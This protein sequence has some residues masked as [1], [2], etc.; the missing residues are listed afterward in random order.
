MDA[1]QVCLKI[2]LVLPDTRASRG[3][4]R[5]MHPRVAG[6]EQSRVEGELGAFSSIPPLTK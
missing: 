3:Q 1:G 4:S 5:T 2:T 6:M